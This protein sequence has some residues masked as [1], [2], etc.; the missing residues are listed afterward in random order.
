MNQK[1][2]IDEADDVQGFSAAASIPEQQYNSK[3]KA[4]SLNSSVFL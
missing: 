4:D 1:L 3:N 2:K